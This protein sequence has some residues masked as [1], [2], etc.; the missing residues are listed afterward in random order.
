LRTRRTSRTW[1]AGRAGGTRV[2]GDV[3]G[4]RT[5]QREDVKACVGRDAR[6]DRRR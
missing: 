2:A 3:P 1:R 5:Q 4:L 6:G